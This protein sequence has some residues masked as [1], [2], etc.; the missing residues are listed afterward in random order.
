MSTTNNEVKNVS[1]YRNMKDVP[2]SEGNGIKPWMKKATFEWVYNTITSGVKKNAVEE[3]RKESDKEKKS[4]LKQEK[5]GYF[6]IGL[7]KENYRLD[8]N[9]I[10][11]EFMLFDFDHLEGEINEYKN[12]LKENPM[13]YAAF[14][15][16]SGDG[17]KVIF[18]L[19]KPITDP[20]IFTV[21]YKH[22]A[23]EFGAALGI[24]ADKTSDVS[25]PCFFSNDPD[26]YVNEN[27]TPLSIEGKLQIPGSTKIK[28]SREELLGAYKGVKE[29]SR[30]TSLLK[31]VSSLI[32]RHLDFEFILEL[33]IGWNL[34]NIPPLPLRRSY[35]YCNLTV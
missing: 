1:N 17:L 24:A 13:V 7:F 10:S 4:V 27:A 22:Y 11:T 2:V 29:G 3:I 15:S 19:D 26:M 25:R 28:I 14:I 34:K 12:K 31:V 9:L 5:L 8:K 30:N 6:N 32:D 16:P 23:Q 18:R 35:I 20:K 33:A 21:W